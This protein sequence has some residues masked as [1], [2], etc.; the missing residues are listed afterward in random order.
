MT[1]LSLSESHD[2]NAEGRRKTWIC[3]VCEGLLGWA[4]PS[5]WS[6]SSD[7]L[8]QSAFSWAAPCHWQNLQLTKIL[9]T[10]QISSFFPARLR[11]SGGNPTPGREACCEPGRAGNAGRLTFSV[12]VKLADSGDK[13]SSASVEPRSTSAEMLGCFR[14]NWNIF[15]HLSGCFLESYVVKLLVFENVIFTI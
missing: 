15:Q 13:R 10:A 6:L 1:L 14:W 7:R 12:K 2:L 9:N 11:L 4:G 8:Q 5:V 3:C